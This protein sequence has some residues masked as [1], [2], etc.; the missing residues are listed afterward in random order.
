MNVLPICSVVLFAAS[1]AHAQS[2]SGT[3]LAP[4]VAPASTA[5]PAPAAA[6]ETPIDFSPLI[7]EA[8]INAPPS[9]VW[10]VFTTPEGFKL[11]G[12]AVVDIDFRVG[13]LMRS[14][15][16]PKVDLASDKAIHNQIIAFEPGR[17][18][19]FRI[20]QPP[21]GFPF[22]NAYKSTWSVATFTDLGD[23][24]T[25]LRLAGMGYTAEAESQAMR[26]FFKSGNA[27]TI[28][29][30]QSHFDSQVKVESP[31]TAHAEKPLD[32]IEIETMVAGAREEVFRA[33]TTNAGWKSFFDKDTNIEAFPGGPFEIYM[34]NTAPVGQRGSEGCKVLSIVPNEMFSYTWN[35]P[36]K[37]EFARQNHTWVVVTFTSI[38]PTLTKV[39]ARHLGFEERAAKH[40]EHADEFVQCRAYFSK[41]WPKVFGAL[42]AKFDP[43]KESAEE[44][45]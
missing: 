18:L 3:K 39:K 28:K 34:G 23:G 19:A 38:S 12:P 30:L 6:A 10:K 26:N 37:F 41:A 8:I 16:D 11:L 33:Y 27:W 22:M 40:P 42:K 5:T 36:P 35:A 4:A 14:S 1:I 9:E 7:H 13:G 43:K 29:K 17:M 31:A 32:P 44:K 21:K 24:R 25:S 2:P 15:Y 20:V 45:K